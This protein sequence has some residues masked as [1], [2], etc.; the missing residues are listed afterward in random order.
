[1]WKISK[2]TKMVENSNR[3][4]LL[5]N[6]YIG[7]N[8]LCK[9]TDLD[10]IDIIL[11]GDIEKVSDS[12]RNI[13]ERKGIIVLDSV[14]ENKLL[15]MQY[16]RIASPRVMRLIINPTESC[17]FACK[18]CYEEHVL[19]KMTQETQNDIVTFVGKNIQNYTGIHV[20]WFG[21][22]PLV[23]KSSLAY[24][25]NRIAKICKFNKRKYTADMTTNAYL[26]DY[27]TFNEML[28][29][30]IKKFQITVDGTKDIHDSQRVLKNG[31][32]TYDQI[33]KNLN[34]IKN[35]RRRDFKVLIRVNFTEKLYDAFE[36]FY[37]SIESFISDDR[38]YISFFTV[39]DI[40]G[41]AVEEL[42]K[43]ILDNK[44]NPMKRIYDLIYENSKS[45]NLAKELLNPGMSLCYGGKRD[46]FVI[47]ADGSVY[48]CTIDFEDKKNQVG[49]LANGKMT[50]FDKYYNY[51][52]DRYK[53]AEYYE[54]FFAPVCTGDPCPKKD[55][56]QK[57]CS[58]LK[59]NMEIVLCIMD[60]YSGFEVIDGGMCNEL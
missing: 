57:N 10:N 13:L 38:F 55:S 14:D 34:A 5:Y 32:G 50:L 12:I 9:L 18:Y 22:E 56:K 49:I 23:N 59:E 1:M 44:R 20:S 39:K 8:S 53:C 21:G 40:E 29:Y 11:S 4:L 16:Y 2:F 30:N 6:S 41:T 54:C 24:I 15:D 35:S 33:L 58:F 45:L 52:S 46:N 28:S 19:N 17:N 31:K 60:K 7:E 42:K 48:K 37:K 43:D 25:S 47:K 26:L 3:E 51:I 36:E 27:D